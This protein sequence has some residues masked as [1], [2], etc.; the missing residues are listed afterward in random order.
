MNL[1]APIPR[2]ATLLAITGCFGTAA[3]A[4]AAP[5]ASNVPAAAFPPERVRLTGGVLKEIQDLHHHGMVGGLEPDRL[6][7]RFRR[8]AGLPQPEGVTG[9]YGSWDDHFI[10]GHYA[11]HYLSGAARMYAAT[12][13]AAYRDK[14]RYMVKVLAECQQRLGGGYLSAFP[15]EKFDRLEANPRGGS[16]EYYT[17]H[18]ILAGLV[19]VARICDDDTAYQV[20]ARMSDHFAARMAK[21]TPEQ[22][23]LLLRTD[24]TGNPVNEFGGMAEALTD[25]C[26]LARERG[27]ARADRHLDFARVFIRDWLVEPLLRG[28]DRLDGLHGNTHA[29]QAAGIAHYALVTGREREARAARQFLDFVVRDHSFVNGGNSFHEK[30][31]ASGVEVAGT[32][33]AVLN[34]LTAESCNTHNML[35]LARHLARISPDAALADYQE[36]ALYNHLVATVAPDHGRVT[37]YLSMRPGDHRVHVPDPVCCQGTGIELAGRLAEGLYTHR[38]DE[39]WVHGYADSTLDWRE[40]R[41]RLRQETRYPEDGAVRIH[42]EADAPVRATL[43]L[44]MPGW[45]DAP[46]EVRLNGV[47]LA[48]GVP[49]ACLPLTREWKNGDV[50]TFEFPMKLRVRPARDDRAMVSFFH[51]PLL[52][53]GRLGREGMPES[54][55]QG[56]M[57]LEHVP[58]WPAPVRVT[59]RPEEPDFDLRAVPDRPGEYTMTLTDPRNRAPVTVRLAPFFRV[60]H[61]RYALYWRS[62]TPEAFEKSFVAQE[63]EVAS[64]IGRPDLEQAAQLQGEHSNTGLFRQRHWRDAA[65][66]GW[67]SYRLAIPRQE[68]VRLVCTYWGGESIRREFEVRVEDRLVATQ[69]LE[70]NQP[71]EFFDA[72]HPL[73]DDLLHGRQFVT[74]RFQGKPGFQAGGLFGLRLE[75]ASP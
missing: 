48:S 59:P 17:I 71:G 56:H 21:L 63:R 73:P 70:N 4:C 25:L 19:D 67:F 22:T 16:V 13:D 28:E 33:A 40:N 53:A 75:A 46:V 51:G 57:A 47:A 42:L 49:G 69:V 8:Q 65:P 18:K 12:G 64:F 68:N 24:Y 2:I 27:D 54:D 1:P 39:L 15:E 5:A 35:K 41:L 3:A 52:L 6:L 9:G 62:L 45:L 38:G 20:A 43:H 55:V 14:A 36:N 30:L 23:E 29:A 32:G 50:L 66:G 72:V 31:R 58:A 44:R 37:Y 34:A 61:E 26:L 7:F 60:H 74:I 11:G 10:A